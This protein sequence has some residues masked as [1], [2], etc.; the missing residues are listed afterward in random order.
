MDRPVQRQVYSLQRAWSTYLNF[1]DLLCDG[2]HIRIPQ[3]NQQARLTRQNC[4]QDEGEGDGTSAGCCDDSGAFGSKFAG[5]AEDTPDGFGGE[6]AGE[7]Q[8]TNQMCLEAREGHEHV[9]GI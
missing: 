7:K 4:G 1:E 2:K 5:C 3:Q 8:K 6:N 9:T